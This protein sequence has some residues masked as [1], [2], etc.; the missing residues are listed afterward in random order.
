MSDRLYSLTTCFKLLDDAI[1]DLKKNFKSYEYH[2]IIKYTKRIF[3]YNYEYVVLIDIDMAMDT[4]SGRVR[5]QFFEAAMLFQQAGGKIYVYSKHPK[6][7]FHYGNLNA[8]SEVITDM[9]LDDKE[10]ASKLTKFIFDQTNTN[11][12]VFIFGDN[13]VYQIKLNN[14]YLIKDVTATHFLSFYQDQD[15][16]RKY[17]VVENLML[18]LGLNSRMLKMREPGTHYGN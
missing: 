12:I 9:P 18:Y 4:V 11:D 16:L 1:E 14:T 7:Y 15:P 6:E 5:D 3:Y 2:D 13:M 10:K 17:T 8:F